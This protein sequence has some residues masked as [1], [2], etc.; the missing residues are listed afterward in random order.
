MFALSAPW[1]GALGDRFDR[2]IVMIASDLA[3][4]GV[5]VAFAFVHKPIVL[6][7]LSGV[8]ALAEADKVPRVRAIGKVL[9]A[10]V[11]FRNEVGG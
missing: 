5:F 7:V 1:A 6:V 10:A 11:R 2:R 3:A 9:A 4:A 8:A